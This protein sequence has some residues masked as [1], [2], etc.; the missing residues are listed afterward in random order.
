MTMNRTYPRNMLISINNKFWPPAKILPS[1]SPLSRLYGL[2]RTDLYVL[3]YQ[4]NMQNLHCSRMPGT[5]PTGQNC[6][7]SR[8]FS[9][10]LKP[11]AARA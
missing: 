2:H 5:C 10:G 7:G 8:A 6:D 9:P 11:D 4:Q 3:I 1:F